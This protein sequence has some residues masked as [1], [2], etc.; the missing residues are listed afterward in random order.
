V[1]PKS[2][3]A[4]SLNAAELC[5]ARYQAEFITYGKGFSG[6]AAGVGIVCHG[7]FERFVRG[8]F[9]LKDILWEEN[10]YW[11]IFHEEYEKVFGPDRDKPE[12]EDA[13]DLC[14]RWYYD[15]GQ[16]DRLRAVKILS[17]ESKNNFMVKTSAGEIPVNYI[18]DRL[19]QIGPTEYR[20]VDYKSNRI[21]LT[22]EQM[23]KKIQPRLYALAI[24]IKFPKA[25]TVWVEFDFLRHDRVGIAFTRED[26]VQTFRMLQRA[27]KRIIDTPDTKVPETLNPECGWCVRKV[28]CKTLQNNIAAG[29]IMSKDENELAKIHKVLSMQAKAQKEL[30]EEIE[31]MLLRRAITDDVLEYETDEAVIKVVAKKARKPNHAAI[32][33]ILGEEEAGRVSSFRVSDVDRLIKTGAVTDNQATLLNLAMPVE[34]SDPRVQI[35]LKDA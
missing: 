28:D 15:D 29:G 6:S 33:A 31:L 13:H 18:M 2:F 21:A 12:Y 1:I 10:I 7:T 8:C 11:T 24:Q 30:L 3:S 14:R 27:I 25:T 22:G 17:V 16:E 5:L 32:R 34:V 20:I 4:T 23:K 19:E 26:N 35:E 9:I